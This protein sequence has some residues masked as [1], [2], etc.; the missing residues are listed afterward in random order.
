VVEAGV[1]AARE[2]NHELTSA[3]Q[4]LRLGWFG[5]VSLLIG[6]LVGHVALFDWQID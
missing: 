6:S 4:H 3:V 2:R 1:V 5:S